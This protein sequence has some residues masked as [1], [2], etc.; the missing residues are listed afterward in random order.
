MS[1]DWSVPAGFSRA[2]QAPAP[3]LL[4]EPP[5]SRVSLYFICMAALAA[6]LFVWPGIYFSLR[7]LEERR[8][9]KVQQMEYWKAAFA[10]PLEQ[11]MAPADALL[12]DFVRLRSER[13]GWP[14]R[15]KSYAPDAQMWRDLNAAVAAL[16]P[17]VK[18]A[19][20][21]KLGGIVLMRDG[22]FSGITYE[23][24]DAQGKPAKGFIMINMV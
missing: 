20:A 8:V 13:A 5:R 6:L 12:I 21:D 9:E 11:R 22:D 17:Q 3:R 14:S 4:E 1:H 19:A 16:P 2:K 18:R 10:L 7:L 24:M 15:P 23:I